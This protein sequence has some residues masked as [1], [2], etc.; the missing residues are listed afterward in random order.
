MIAIS[1]DSE[2]HPKN[3]A[4]KF[5]FKLNREWFEKKNFIDHIDHFAK[6]D[7]YN[8]LVESIAPDLL[9][10]TLN[11][12]PE[13]VDDFDHATWLMVS[14]VE[15][16]VEVEVDDIPEWKRSGF[17]ALKENDIWVYIPPRAVLSPSEYETLVEDYR[18]KI[19]G[20]NACFTNSEGH[21]YVET[22]VL[23]ALFP[24][25]AD[26]IFNAFVLLT[27]AAL[28]EW[29]TESDDDEDEDFYLNDS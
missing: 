25:L 6:S 16:G 18:K 29:I 26:T 19:K 5:G 15:D 7:S 20:Y 12:C 13:D 4:K 2:F 3:A 10:S 22:K 14:K 11:M 8:D 21:L 17:V 27:Q 28:S 23:T 9:G 24:D 1:E